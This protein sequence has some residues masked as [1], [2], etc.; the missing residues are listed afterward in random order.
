MLNLATPPNDR[1]LPHLPF[2]IPGG[3][4]TPDDGGVCKHSANRRSRSTTE[5]KHPFVD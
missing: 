4:F 2:G 3:R 5:T 1:I